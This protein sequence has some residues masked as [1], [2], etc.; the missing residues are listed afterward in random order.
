MR[1]NRR[2]LAAAIL[3]LTSMGIIGGCAGP[4][5]QK[6]YR[7]FTR[8]AGNVMLME[9]HCH[10]L[11]AWHMLEAKHAT[12]VHIDAHDDC[13]PLSEEKLHRIRALLEAGDYDQVFEQS[14]T[15]RFLNLKVRDEDLLYTLGD[16]IYPAMELGLVSNTYWIVPQPVI[17]PAER[18][19]LTALMKT[20]LPGASV[21]STRFPAG[22]FELSWRGR[23]FRVITFEDLPA[24]PSG[25]LLD[26]DIDVFAFRKAMTEEHLVAQVNR[27]PA[28]VFKYLEEKVPAP[29]AVTISASVWGGYLPLLLRFLADAAFD[30]Y[31]T[32]SFPADAE[33]LLNSYKDIRTGLA[34]PPPPPSNETYLP[35][36][37][38]FSALTHLSKGD[39]ELCLKH[40]SRAADICPVYR[41]GLLDAAEALTSMGRN[42]EAMGFIEKF[43][44]RGGRT[45]NS[46]AVR[47]LSLLKS[48][49][50]KT[51]LDISHELHGWSSNP[52]TMLIYGSALVANNRGAEAKKVFEE[53]LTKAPGHSAAHF[54]LGLIHQ[55][56]ANAPAAITEYE[57]AIRSKTDFWQARENLGHL[58][59]ETGRLTEAEDMLKSTLQ[60]N[61]YSVTSVNNLG[62]ALARQRRYAEAIEMFRK[63]LSLAPRSSTLKLN[64]AEALH[65]TGRAKEAYDLCEQVIDTEDEVK[66][67]ALMRK[68]Q[69]ATPNGD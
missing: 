30:F 19:R 3:C 50:A 43:E 49:D 47:A 54:N 65:A 69:A 25:C 22:G 34:E 67:R 4:P 38:H 13:R 10:S 7:G 17:T 31:T 1:E 20:N 33:I 18:D 52:Y 21:T 37:L 44:A 55:Q 40:L 29:A 2:K 6:D 62:L 53:L 41:K 23:F 59:L 28:D 15:E 39:A 12:L 9:N 16:F 45:Y 8:R 26:I 48:G 36:W 57:R 42:T 14:D 27:N 11:V 61:P 68:L 63:G 32:G 35:A 46:R 64:L 51:A 24:L 60:I 66:A 5:G 56:A 58:L